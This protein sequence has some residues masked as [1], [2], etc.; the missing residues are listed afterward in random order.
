MNVTVI[1]G[2]RK[3]ERCQLNINTSARNFQHKGIVE[4]KRIK[5]SNECLFTHE[6]TLLRSPLATLTWCTHSPSLR[7]SKYP[8]AADEALMASHR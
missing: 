8:G 5:H 7:S 4:D 2:T 3:T 6:H 1:L